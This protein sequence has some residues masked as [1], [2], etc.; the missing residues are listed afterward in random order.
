MRM[1]DTMH[2]EKGHGAS[3]NIDDFMSHPYLAEPSIPQ[4]LR[5]LAEATHRTKFLASVNS[6]LKNTMTSIQTN[7]DNDI[8]A[9]LL[10]I[11]QSAWMDRLTRSLAANANKMRLILR[12]RPPQRAGPDSS[13]SECIFVHAHSN[14]LT[15]GAVTTT[16]RTTSSTSFTTSSRMTS[17]FPH[18][19]L[20]DPPSAQT[21]PRRRLAAEAAEQE[22][23]GTVS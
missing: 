8:D 19:S 20:C 21:R 16:A 4:E 11:S 3:N 1:A 17:A 14:A 5:R 18:T 13:S 15:Q 22:A 2:M 7:T 12:R 9:A 6:I 10:C 23:Q